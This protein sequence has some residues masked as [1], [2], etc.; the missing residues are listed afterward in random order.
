MIG[1]LDDTIRLVASPLLDVAWMAS[2]S[3]LSAPLVVTL[4]TPS[5]WLR[6]LTP[7]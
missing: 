2:P 6:A 5:P 1:P 7:T 4:T 3:V